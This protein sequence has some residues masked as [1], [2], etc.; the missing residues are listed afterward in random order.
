M[1]SILYFFSLQDDLLRI[2]GGK[3]R[4]YDFLSTL[5]LKCSY[6]LFNKEHVKEIL[7]EAATQKSSGSRQNTQS[8][9]NI[10]VVEKHRTYI[11]CLIWGKFYGVNANSFVNNFRF[12]H[13]LV[14]C[15]F[16]GLKGNW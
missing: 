13:A 10:L 5:S 7:L 15:F 4:L 11:F 1:S 12:L 16:V 3:H 9:M 14:H 2:L 6:L 8:C